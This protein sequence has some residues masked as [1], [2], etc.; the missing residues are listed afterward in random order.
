M[1]F[2]TISLFWGVKSVPALIQQLINAMLT[3]LSGTAAFIDD[4][5]IATE[6]RYELCLF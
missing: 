5:N 6:T 4:I 3:G 2:I 1:Y